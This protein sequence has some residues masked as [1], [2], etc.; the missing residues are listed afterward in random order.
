M[1]AVGD[2]HRVHDFTQAQRADRST[3]VFQ[4]SSTPCQH[5]CSAQR[6]SNEIAAF[7]ATQ[8]TA[9]TH[10]ESHT[11]VLCLQKST[12]RKLTKVARSYKDPGVRTCA[13]K[14]GK[15]V[16]TFI[17]N[18][19]S[20]CAFR[21]TQAFS[22]VS[23]TRCSDTQLCQLAQQSTET[24]KLLKGR[25][26]RTAGEAD[27]WQP[28]SPTTASGRGNQPA[29]GNPESNRGCPGPCDIKNNGHHRLGTS[30]KPALSISDWAKV[31]S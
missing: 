6:Q 8:V 10:S 12:V 29:G 16:M 18:R 2:L 7:H 23:V 30:V 26:R 13:T 20:C 9:V 3:R 5:S 24:P 15:K 22:R 25:R 17:T 31:Q 1:C 19:E 27:G 21:E 28:K 4:R 14:A 11:R